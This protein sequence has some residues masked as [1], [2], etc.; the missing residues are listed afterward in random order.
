MTNIKFGAAGIGS[1]KDAEKTLE[2]YS[3]LGL[4]ACEIAFTYEVYIKKEEDARRIGRTA[5]KL[6]IKLSIH[7]P[8]WINLNSDKLEKVEASKKRILDCCKV[9]YWLGA[10]R[11]VFHPGYYGKNKEYAFDNIKLRIREMLEYIKE[12]K[13]DVEICA[14]TMGK[15]NVFGSIEEISEL[16]KETGCGF[17]LDFA[18]ILARDKKVEWKKIEELFPRKDWHCHFSGIEYGAKGEKR[19]KKTEKEEWKHLLENLPEDKNITII[20]EASNPVGD[21]FEGLKIWEEMKK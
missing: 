17:C 20:N 8:Y 6:G 14:E 4:K 11:I 1:V 2:A 13:W 21:S 3:K 10:E 16:A 7:A 9:G 5:E 12:E 18:H 19:H 15:V